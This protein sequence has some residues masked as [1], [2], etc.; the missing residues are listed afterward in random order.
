MR[1]AKMA[2]VFS[3]TMVPL[4]QLCGAIPRM[5]RNGGAEMNVN[6]SGMASIISA[7]VIL[8][9]HLYRAIAVI[10][11]KGGD[12]TDFKTGGIASI[13]SAS[14]VPMRHL[15]EP[16]L[17]FVQVADEERMTSSRLGGFVVSPRPRSVRSSYSV[18]SAQ[19]S[20]G[21]RRR[22]ERR[23]DKPPHLFS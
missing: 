12:E 14:I 8:T 2:G 1:V 16:T 20:Q 15:Y 22:N 19:F 13:F 5:S 6:T 11:A 10:V 9:V 7:P 21:W 23:Q 17:R 4:Q 3:V 18:H